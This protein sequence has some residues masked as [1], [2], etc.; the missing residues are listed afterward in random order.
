MRGDNMSYSKLVAY[1]VCLLMTSWILHADTYSIAIAIEQKSGGL[2]VSSTLLIKMSREDN[3]NQAK[4]IVTNC[5]FSVSQEVKDGVAIGVDLPA[6]IHIENEKGALVRIYNKTI[7]YNLVNDGLIL[8]K[9]NTSENVI[10]GPVSDLLSMLVS[11][12]MN[13]PSV[14]MGNPIAENEYDIKVVEGPHQLVYRLLSDKSTEGMHIEET[15]II[16]SENKD[17]GFS[18]IVIS[19]EV[20]TVSQRIEAIIASDKFMQT[21]SDSIKGQLPKLR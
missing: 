11:S 4:F 14:L 6:K 3:D 16:N 7:V 13:R 1:I 18:R 17:K 19:N 5:V 15:S 9:D 8:Q 10:I 21:V 2:D 12:P 20:L